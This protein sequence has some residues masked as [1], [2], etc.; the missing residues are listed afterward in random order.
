MVITPATEDEDPPAVSSSKRRRKPPPPPSP[1][2]TASSPPDGERLSAADE[3]LVRLREDESLPWKEVAARFRAE[4]GRDFSVAA[5]QMR[6][7]RLRE[8]VRPWTD[9][10]V[11]ALRMAHDYW[12]SHKFE[13]IAA[14]VRSLSF[15]CAML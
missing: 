13:I 15:D 3:L 4:T 5:L 11:L 1:S 6:L 8:R 9:R 14:K 12:I 7:K 10:D 2:S